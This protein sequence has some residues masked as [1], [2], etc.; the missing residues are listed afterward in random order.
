MSTSQELAPAPTT[1]ELLARFQP[2][3]DEIAA[4]AVKREEKRELAY[5]DVARLKE[6]GFGA[7]RVPSEFGGFGATLSQSIFLLSRLGEADSNLVQALRAH[8]ATV[9]VLRVDSSE[10]QALWYPRIVDGALLGNATTERGNLPGKNS[11]VLTTRDGKLFLNGTKFYSTGSLYADYIK[12]HADTEDGRSARVVVHRSAPGLE[13]V[14]DWDGFGQRLTASGTTHLRDIEVQPEDVE[15][16]R[17]DSTAG[18]FAAYAQLILLTALTGIGRA[19]RRDAVEYVRT[20]ARAFSNGVGSEPQRDPL[21][22]EVIGRVS[23]TVFGVESALKAA[24]EA[25]EEA[26]TLA[27][28]QA[29]TEEKLATVDTVISEAQIVIVE[30]VLDATNRLFEVGGASATSESRRLDRHWRN[31]RVI[32]QHNPIIY[33]AREV[34]QQRL[35]GDHVTTPVYV[36]QSDAAQQNRTTQKATK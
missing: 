26:F 21:I 31:A 2:I 7:L 10:Q 33:R 20:R 32:G 27:E 5:D 14:D 12:V 19:A 29:L 36:G 34:G 4:G 3:F 28:S 11:T 24:A 6:A 23:A 17:V 15:P 25:V 1:D 16:Y 35:T 22:Q 13:L 8:F 9:E 30:Q 18:P